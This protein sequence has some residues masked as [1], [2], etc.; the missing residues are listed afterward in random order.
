MITIQDNDYLGKVYPLSEVEE[1]LYIANKPIKQLCEEENL[2]I[3]PLDIEDSNDKIGE[4]SIVSIYANEGSSVRI[5]TGN[6]MGFIGRNNQYLKI[7]SRFD[8]D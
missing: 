4:N 7:Y 5:K 3:Y 8:N 1:L 6:I 2:L